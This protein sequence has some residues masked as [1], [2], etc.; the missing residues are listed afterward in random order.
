MQVTL[1]HVEIKPENVDDFI[2]ASRLNHES[3]IKETGNFRFDVI[4]LLD[5]PCKFVLY[6]AYQSQKDAAKHKETPHYLAWRDTVADWMA[7]P[8]QGIPYKGLFPDVG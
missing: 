1:V 7:V 3:S 2:E 8:R 4:Q 5:N 6:E